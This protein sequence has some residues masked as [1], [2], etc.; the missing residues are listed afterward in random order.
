MYQECIWYSETPC[1]VVLENL[2][3]LIENKSHTIDPS[4]MLYHAQIVE[5]L[6]E[7]LIHTVWENKNQSN[8][9]TIVTISCP[10]NEMPSIFHCIINMLQ[11]SKIFYNNS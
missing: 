11:I 4:S 9:V 8:I 2:D 10:F 3:L 6:K 1:L 5:A 7:L